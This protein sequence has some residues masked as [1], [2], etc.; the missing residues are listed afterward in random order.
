V[1]QGKCPNGAVCIDDADCSNDGLTMPKGACKI[2][3]GQKC[4]VGSIKVDSCSG[5]CGSYAEGAACQCDD[6][7]ESWNDCCVDYKALCDKTLN[8]MKSQCDKGGGNGDA[9]ATDAG[10][11]DAG[12]TDAGTQDTGPLD[13]GVVDSGAKDAGSKDSGPSDAG[14]PDVAPN[15]TAPV[16]QGAADM[17]KQ[18]NAG[19]SD[20]GAQADQGAQPDNGDSKTA[21]ADSAVAADGG[22]PPIDSGAAD[23]QGGFAFATAAPQPKGCQAGTGGSA[24]GLSLM[25]CLLLLAW[26]RRERVPVAL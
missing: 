9:G 14:Q 25:L 16:D 18:D 20:H 5:K 6:Q 26:R 21:G 4:Y 23:S 2:D 15:D 7:C 19:Q 3:P 24:G 22:P 8:P 1:C 13:A 17:A 12:S 11:T 10:S